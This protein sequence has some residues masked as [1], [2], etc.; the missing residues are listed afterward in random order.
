MGYRRHRRLAGNRTGD[1]TDR[2]SGP[3]IIPWPAQLCAGGVSDGEEMA[4][5][6]EVLVRAALPPNSSAGPF[7]RRIAI[8]MH[9]MLYNMPYKWRSA[10]SRMWFERWDFCAW[11][12][13][14]G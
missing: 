7:R 13:G 4:R 2:T 1:A 3:A 11:A 5:L 9:Y 12:A 14:C 8:L 10:W 6:I